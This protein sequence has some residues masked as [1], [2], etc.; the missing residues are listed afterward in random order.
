MASRAATRTE[1][2]VS[3]EEDTI[4]GGTVSIR[5]ETDLFRETRLSTEDLTGDNQQTEARTE[6]GHGLN[7][8]AGASPKVED[9]TE[10][11]VEGAEVFEAG[12]ATE[13]GTHLLAASIKSGDHEEQAELPGAPGAKP[14][15]TSNASG[16]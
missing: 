6:T 1:E 10:A 14:Q 15:A 11:E 3:L 9:N 7:L 2:E 16:V 12:A 4:R 5:I 13:A 8:V